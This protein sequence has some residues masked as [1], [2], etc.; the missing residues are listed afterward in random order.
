MLPSLLLKI[1]FLI[2]ASGQTYD[3]PLDTYVN[4]ADPTYKYVDTGIKTSGTNIAGRWTAYLL[5]MTSQTWLNETYVNKPVWW[6]WLWVIIPDEVR[7][8]DWGTV[9]VTGNKNS[10]QWPNKNEEYFR[11]AQY[12]AT[13]TKTILSVLYYIP[14]EPLIFYND[15]KHKS[16]SED[17]IIAFGWNQYL[18]LYNEDINNEYRYN[19]LVLFPM[20]KAVVKAMDTMTDYLSSNKFNNKY[21]IQRFGIAGA[22]KRGWTTWLTAAVDKRVEVFIPM[23]FDM[24]NMHRSL[25]HMWKAYGGWTFAFEDYYDENITQYLDTDG[26][27]SIMNATD[28]IMFFDRYAGKYKMPIDAVNDE[29][30]MTDDEYYWW[31]EFPEPR[32]FQMNPDAE[33]SLITA[34]EELVPTLSTFTTLYLED[35]PMPTIEWQVDNITG[36]IS[37]SFKGNTSQIV[38]AVVWH[39]R[40]CSTHMRDFRLINLDHPCRCGVPGGGY[41]INLESVFEPYKIKP[42]SIDSTSVVY[43]AG[44][45]S[46]PDNHWSGFMVAIR[47]KFFNATHPYEKKKGKCYGYEG[48]DDRTF[49]V[50]Y[51]E[52]QFT[53]QVSIMPKTFPF[54]DCQGVGCYGTLV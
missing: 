46:V 7:H 40:S 12:V 23:V 9:V 44:P 27:L 37:I 33:H 41:C 17:A 39:G 14:N 36:N 52:M 4:A 15:P 50:E 30:F 32:W 20:T 13:H 29:F 54:T 53:T 34:I 25:H 10:A 5:N 28:P 8:T 22:S 18:Q 48:Q 35:Y 11:C 24:E 47:V 43:E 49:L 19:W 51:G 3:T 6:H 16:R 38:E 2:I 21:N 45:S 31:N 1:C 42:I 26:F